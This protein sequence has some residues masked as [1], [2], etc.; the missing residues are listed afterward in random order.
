[1]ANAYNGEMD[2]ELYF[3]VYPMKINMGVIASFQ[4]ETGVDF[5]HIAIKAINAYN[6]SRQSDSTF[7]RAEL[8]TEAVSMEHAAYLFFLAAKEK[9]ST[10]TFEEI[11]EAVLLDGPVERFVDVEGSDKMLRSYPLAFA[12]LATFAALGAVDSVK[13]P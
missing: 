6:K 4:A 10:V 3:K 8:M 13:K 2:V 1:M 11:Q 12:E 9:D 7:E 5:M